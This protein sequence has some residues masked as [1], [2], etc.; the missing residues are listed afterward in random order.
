MGDKYHKETS[1]ILFFFLKFFYL[2]ALSEKKELKNWGPTYSY[3]TGLIRRVT[4]L[5][6]RLK[7][8]SRRGQRS[9]SGMKIIL[10]LQV[11]SFSLFCL[12]PP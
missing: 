5:C 8:V 2:K 9:N 3:R 7:Q 10:S 12:T 4:R 6:K 11:N 1:F